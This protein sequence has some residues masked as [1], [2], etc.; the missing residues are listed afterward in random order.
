MATVVRELE[1]TQAA[2]NGRELPRDA[3]PYMTREARAERA[4]WRRAHFKEWCRDIETLSYYNPEYAYDV[5][6]EYEDDWTT[7]PDHNGNGIEFAEYDADGVLKPIDDRRWLLEGPMLTTLRKVLGNRVESQGC[8][9]FPV[10]IAERLA[11]LTQGGHLGVHDQPVTYVK[12]NLMVFPPHFALPAGV[13]RPRADCALRLHRDAPPP[14]LVVEILTWTTVPQDLVD[15]R[16]LYAALGVR[17]YWVCDVGGIRAAD[18]PVELQVFRLTEAGTYAPV[19]SDW[20]P[21]DARRRSAAPP[22]PA[23]RSAACGTHV[24][25]TAGAYA[26]RFQ[27]WDAV[28]ARWRDTETDAQDERDRIRRES[29]QEGAAIGMERAREEGRAE[30]RTAMAVAVMR[31]FL[32]EELE[33]VD[34]DRIEAVWRRNGPPNDY[35]RRVKAVLRTVNEWPILLQDGPWKPDDDCPSSGDEPT[36]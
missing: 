11:L 22:L 32:G 27:W 23:F 21:E 9:Y 7:D 14:E 6:H 18:S 35:L 34:L 5:G 36:G 8:V 3:E 1:R 15:K 16:R 13:R 26:P 4:A 30:A 20:E 2:P 24:R 31:E 10:P 25:L 28:Q 29:W 33:A 17:E 12:P 19:A